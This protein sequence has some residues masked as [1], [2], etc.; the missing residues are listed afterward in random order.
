MSIGKEIKKKVNGDWQNAFSELSLYAQSKLYKVVSPLIIG[1]E[2]IKSPFTDSYSPYLV[3]YPLWKK[4]LKAIFDYPILLRDF[5]TKK[6]FQYDIPYEN[7]GMFF[8]DVLDSIRKQSP[9]PFEGNISLK[10]LVAV[11]DEYSKTPPLSASPNS[12]LQADLQKA[13]LK[14]AL[15]V[16]SEEA[17]SIL[18]QIHKRNWDVNHFKACGININKWFQSL[19]DAIVERDEFLN[20]IDASKQNKKIANLQSS[21]LTE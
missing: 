2:L 15:T 16:S 21:E 5:K 19:H 10:Q 20:Q 9:L 11:L 18:E 13:K 17:Q 12:Y 4:D 7:H 3:I 8:D 6:G 1:L 14:I